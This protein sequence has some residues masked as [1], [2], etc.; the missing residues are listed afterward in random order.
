MG[1]AAE[2]GVAGAR[3]VT[4]AAAGVVAVVLPA[5]RVV[6]R[7]GEREIGRCPYALTINLSARK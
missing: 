4:P 7:R 2:A 6:V 3:E 1:V 5:V